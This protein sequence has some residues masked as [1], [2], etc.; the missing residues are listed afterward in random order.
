MT[1]KLPFA[2]NQLCKEALSH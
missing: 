1:Y 2:G